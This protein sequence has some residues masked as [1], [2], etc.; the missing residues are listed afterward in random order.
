MATT[1][2]SRIND[3]KGTL[4]LNGRFDF[5]I[6]RDFRSNYENIIN[7]SGVNELEVDLN[8]VDYI[9]SSALGMLLLLREKA[10]DKNIKMRLT[11]P[12]DSVR[13]VL[14]VAN[15]GRLFTIA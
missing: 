10:M 13:Q 15:F 12:K 14:E 1:V 7:T 11:N 8:A 5:S 2:S 4:A 9:D 3:H 6:H